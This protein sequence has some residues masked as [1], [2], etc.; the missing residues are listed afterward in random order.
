M[1]DCRRG[2]KD[3]SRFDGMSTAELERLLCRDFMASGEE[4]DMDMVLYI[5][6]VM[7]K[8]EGEEPTGRYTGVEDA[9]A[10]FQEHYMPCVGDGL[11][12]YG[13]EEEPD[14]RGAAAEASPAPGAKRPKRFARAACIAAAAAVLLMGTAYAA[15]ALPWLPGWDSEMFWF[16]GPEETAAAAPAPAPS[17][18][19]FAALEEALV[20]YGA[21]DNMV[22]A[23]IPEGYE[24]GEFYCYNTGG[25]DVFMGTLW[26]DSEG[27]AIIFD[28]VL[29][30]AN[31]Q[32]Y[33]ENGRTHYYKDEGDPEI[34]T[35]GGVEHYIMT[36]AGKYLAVWQREDFECSMSGFASREEL[37]KTIDS[38]Y[39]A[40]NP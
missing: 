18:R 26:S 40:E 32:V 34:Y 22:P 17:P 15:G 24:L 8:R 6:E 30:A 31:G 20:Y 3:F 23:Y 28:Y 11:S 21:P 14:A 19:T 4:S 27:S 16:A 33:S 39:T 29:Y 12:L 38:M 5:L 37:I 1:S 10:S 13:G 2:H 9:W 25:G 7:E 35:A 36:N